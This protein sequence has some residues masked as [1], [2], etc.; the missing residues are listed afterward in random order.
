MWTY[1]YVDPE[2]PPYRPSGRHM[3][4]AVAVA[5]LVTLLAAAMVWPPHVGT[6]GDALPAATGAHGPI[7]A[8]ATPQ[9]KTTR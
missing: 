8:P 5:V 3:A 7:R 2:H 6:V 4:L 9:P 1:A